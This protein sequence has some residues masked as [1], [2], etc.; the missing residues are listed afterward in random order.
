MRIRTIDWKNNKIRI[1]DQSQIPLKVVYLDL[2]CLKDL[3]QAIKSMRVRGAPA[4]GAAAGLGMYLGVKSCVCSDWTGFSRR[5]NTVAKFLGSSRPTARNLF[6]GIERIKATALANKERPVA[7]IKQAILAEALSIMRQD[8]AACRKLGDYGAK[9]LKNNNRV[10]TICNAG[11]LAT[12]DYG[13]ALGVIYSACAQGKQIKVFA[14]ETR[15]LL[16]GGRLSSWELHKQGID[17]T[18]IPDNTAAKLM[19]DGQIDMVITG[20]DRIAANG[21]TANKIGTLNLAVLA[22]Y[23]KVPFYVA[24]PKTTFDLALQ[25]K[26]GI[27]IEMRKAQE[28]SSIL[29]RRKVAPQGAKILNPAFDVTAH[30]LI[31]GIITDE[32]IIRPPYL[33]NIRKILK[34]N[35]CK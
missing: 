12:I 9:L 11:I 24:A 7:K 27:K 14:S 1:I 18:L 34:E 31:S 2:N 29:F 15:P 16:Q 30:Q 10:L 25:D 32:G 4:L 23:H 22:K 3:W 28:V 6:W 8:M 35:K 20:A 19:Q 5:L 13:T 21:D 26:T 33:Q 17:V